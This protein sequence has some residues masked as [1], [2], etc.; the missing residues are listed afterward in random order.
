MF[1]CILCIE[2]E[3]GYPI[4]QHGGQCMI[5][6]PNGIKIVCCLH[7]ELNTEVIYYIG[8]EDGIAIIADENLRF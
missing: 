6:D 8:D 3:D 5:S 4:G 2:K 7:P 1:I